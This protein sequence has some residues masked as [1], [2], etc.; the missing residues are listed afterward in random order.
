[1]KKLFLILVLVLSVAMFWACKKTDQNNGSTTEETTEATTEETTEA[2]TEA[3]TEETTETT[4][5]ATTETTTETTTEAEEH[6]LAEYY[7]FLNNVMYTYQGE[8][9]EFAFFTLSVDVY[10]E[11][12]VQTRMNNGGT[13]IVNV[14]EVSSDRITRILSRPECYYREGFLPKTPEMKDVLLEAPL[15][16]GN[17][18]TAADGSRRYISGTDVEVV[19]PAGTFHAVEV[20]TERA[21]DTNKDYYAP[22]IGL[23]KTIWESKEGY[24]VSSTLSQISMNRPLVQHIRFFYPNGNVDGLY[25]VDRDITFNT[26]DI[27]RIVIQKAFKNLPEGN[28]ARVLTENVKINWLYLNRDGM[29]Y[30]DFSQELVSEMNAG[31]GYE[32]L[33]L[34]S[35]TNTLGSY[36][37]VEKVYLTVEGNPYSSGHID[38]DRGDAFIVD[39]KDALPLP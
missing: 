16:K 17:E 13:E 27:T 34:A 7:P 35:I 39:T 31:A 33:I 30:V 9:N 19:T 5:E 23:V 11:T 3:T 37:G 24:V 20:V 28:V 21:G 6:K 14:I 25:F 8:G 32:A 4:T 1:M 12:R 18:W 10:N 22:G 29:L 26:N 36:Y 15:V 2:T 38:M